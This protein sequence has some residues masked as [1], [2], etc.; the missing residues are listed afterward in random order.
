MVWK[1]FREEEED[2]CITLGHYPTWLLYFIQHDREDLYLPGP[3]RIKYRNGRTNLT[4]TLDV[5]SEIVGKTSTLICGEDAW[6]YPVAWW[7]DY[8][9]YFLRHD[10][11]W[12]LNY[13]VVSLHLLDL[14]SV[15]LNLYGNGETSNVYKMIC[16][17][18]NC[19]L[20][21]A[22]LDKCLKFLTYILLYYS[23]YL[24]TYG[25]FWRKCIVASVK[26]GLNRFNYL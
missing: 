24:H 25:K 16:L 26:S 12:K 11:G 4:D 18:R 5:T 19:S 17:H 3:G 23:C 14:F 9:K 2:F 1:F 7:Q 20:E 13:N 10:S 6:K 15:C 21:N 22:I 8:Q